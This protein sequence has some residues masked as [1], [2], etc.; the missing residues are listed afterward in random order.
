LGLEAGDD[1]ACVHARFEHLH[2]DSAADRLSL[3]SHEDDT[4]AALADRLQHLVGPDHCAGNFVDWL[5]NG[6]DQCGTEGFKQACGV[7]M[8]SQQDLDPAAE[9]LVACAGF[10]QKRGPLVG[11]MVLDRVQE[12]GPDFLRIGAHG[13]PPGLLADRQCE[14]RVEIV[15]VKR[16]KNYDSC[17]S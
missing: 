16:K 15:A 12:Y 11:S 8:C 5:I 7:D 6:F 4:E 13:P 14:K 10:L 2:G 9:V 3:L 1:V 17:R